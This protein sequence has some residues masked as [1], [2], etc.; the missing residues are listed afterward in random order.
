MAAFE[1]AIADGADWIE[2]DVQENADGQ[3][4]VHHDSDFMKQAGVPLKVWDATAEE[5]SDLDVG[6]WFAP[7]FAQ[8]RV[9]TLHEALELARGKV[10]VFIELKYYGHDEQL[11]SRV[12]RTVEAEGMDSSVVI[13]SLKY[14]G[15]RKTAA[16]R[17]DWT[18][19]L[20]TS[21][22]VGDPTRLDVDFLAV[23]SSA[24]T[25]DLVR[26]VHA[27]G[28]KLYAWTVNDP[29]RMSV[30]LS[31]GV[32]GVITDDPALARAVVEFR[33][34]LTPVGRLLVWLAGEAGLFRSWEPP[35]RSDA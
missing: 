31:R 20:L 6:S 30:M 2:L 17:P 22:N 35:P 25:V 1:R 24:A 8:E 5:L 16:I 13:M 21:V 3:V 4:V 14:A 9:P 33:E 34:D 23:N 11:E 26:R 10:G 7:E 29:V 15:V 19:G 32:D 12:V 27:R 28:M 18:Y